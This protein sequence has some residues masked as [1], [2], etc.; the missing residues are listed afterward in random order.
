[1]HSINSNDPGPCRIHI[2]THLL[3]L[4]IYS[5]SLRPTFFFSIHLGLFSTFSFP[6][7]RLPLF[8]FSMMLLQSFFFF[9]YLLLVSLT[10]IYLFLWVYF[11]KISISS[12]RDQVKMCTYFCH[13]QPPAFSLVGRGKKGKVITIRLCDLAHKGSLLPPNCRGCLS[14]LGNNTVMSVTLH[15]VGSLDHFP[16]HWTQKSSPNLTS[17]RPKQFHIF[18]PLKGR[19]CLVS[20]VHFYDTLICWMRGYVHSSLLQCIN[21][22]WVPQSQGGFPALSY[23][24]LWLSLDD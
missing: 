20:S 8:L 15:Q 12:H 13:L 11:W 10:G 23:T 1:M 19:N 5:I 18:C 21:L 7:K 24:A 2:S 6:E 17:L 4:F 9:L 16:L 3:I 22:V 14:Q